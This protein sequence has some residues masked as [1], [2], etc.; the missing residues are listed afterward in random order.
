MMTSHDN[1]ELSFCVVHGNEPKF[2]QLTLVLS[3]FNRLYLEITLSCAAPSGL[4]ISCYVTDVGLLHH[5]TIGLWI[6]EICLE[7]LPKQKCW[8]EVS[9]YKRT[10]MR[11]MYFKFLDWWMKHLTSHQKLWGNWLDLEVG[12]E[13]G[14][15]GCPVLW[16]VTEVSCRKYPFSK[17]KWMSL[18][19]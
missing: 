9:W 1:K 12:G 4:I 11:K 15:Y 7:Y 10:R 13:R 18:R 19:W 6:S 2:W 16:N 8:R 5:D 14:C 17:G 3:A